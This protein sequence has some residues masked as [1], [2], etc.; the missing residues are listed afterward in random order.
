M[1]RTAHR[2]DRLPEPARAE[3]ELEAP[4]REGVERGRLLRDHRRQPERQVRDVRE[5]PDALGARDQVADQRPGLEVTPLV[6][7]VLDPDEVEAELVGAAREGAQLIEIRTVRDEAD[8]EL[9]R[10]TVARRHVD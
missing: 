10:P 3:A 1:H 5:E 8:P 7:V 2:S 6:R 9:D 4:A